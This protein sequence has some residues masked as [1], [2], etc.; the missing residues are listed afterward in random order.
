[1]FGRLICFADQVQSQFF[2]EPSL[3]PASV[4]GTQVSQFQ[5]TSFCGPQAYKDGILYPAIS[6]S[7]TT[8]RS[9]YPK[10]NVENVFDSENLSIHTP[11]YIPGNPKQIEV[12]TDSSVI[13]MLCDGD[14]DAIYILKQHREGDQVKQSAWVR[15]LVDDATIRG[16][17]FFDSKLYVISERVA[18]AVT[19]LW[20]EY[21]DLS[22]GVS[23]LGH[24]WWTMLDRRAS[25]TTITNVGSDT[26]VKM[27]YNLETNAVMEIVNVTT[28]IRYIESSRTAVDTFKVT[29]VTLAGQTCVAGRRY[30]ST[31][32]FHKPEV[33][34]DGQSGRRLIL[35][36]TSAVVR[37]ELKYE[38][39]AYFK[40]VTGS[41]TKSV[42][43]STTVSFTSLT[44]PAN[45]MVVVGVG[46]RLTSQ[47]DCSVQNDSP[48]PHTLV[49]GEW[50]VNAT[51]RSSTAR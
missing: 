37:L 49:S 5:T 32:S 39:T 4:E 18:N 45:E 14:T 17:K 33:Q 29:G 8:L 13:A 23:D 30:T 28:G 35:D 48:W 21:I 12:N 25:P 26:T 9:L 1:M 47:F 22:T 50:L 46:G 40:V 20:L 38:K 36:S 19:E 2:G 27:P 43:N 3:T 10:P 16:I 41:Q 42:G 15:F 7:Y 11:S 51:I 31:H 24:D 44:E 34:V 6:G